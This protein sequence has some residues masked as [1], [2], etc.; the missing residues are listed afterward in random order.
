VLCINP[1]ARLEH[2]KTPVARSG[3]HWLRAEAR[4]NTYL[5][6]RLW[7]GRLSGRC[8]YFWLI[9]GYST[10]ATLAG[11]KGRSAVPWRALLAGIRDSRGTKPANVRC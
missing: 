7:R 10:L 5:Y 6:R 8:C 11:I 2:K 1:R 3:D 4:A 9:F